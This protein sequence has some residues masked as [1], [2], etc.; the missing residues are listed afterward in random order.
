LNRLRNIAL[1]ILTLVLTQ[2]TAQMQQA[3]ALSGLDVVFLIDQSGSM[4]GRA[5]SDTS[6]SSRNDPNGVRFLATQFGIDWLGN[7]RA[8]QALLGNNLDVSASVIYFGDDAEVQLPLV[9]ITS[10]SPALWQEE[11]GALLTPLSEESYS[12]QN[13]GNT[14][15]VAAF[16]TA[17][18]EI[19]ADPDR[20]QVIILLTDGAPCAPER[21]VDE[22]CASFSDWH[23]HMQSVIDTA[24]QQFD[25]SNQYIY[26]VALVDTHIWSVVGNEWQVVSENGFS[27]RLER[28]EEFGIVFNEIL[29][30]SASQF[31]SAG[32]SARAQLGINVNLP[33]LGL[34]QSAI[35]ANNGTRELAIPPYQQLM[36]ISLFK[37]RADAKLILKNPYGD[38]LTS[39]SQ[40]V[41]VFGEGSL[42]EVW[43]V[44]NP[45]PGPWQIGTQ[46]EENGRALA[47]GYAYASVDLLRARFQLITPGGT[48]SMLRPITVAVEV[49]DAQD[50]V[51][52]LYDPQ[53][54]LS[55]ST[56]VTT[57]GGETLSLTLAPIN[58]VNRYGASFT[59]FEAGDYT[60][61]T[62]MAADEISFVE[63]K[64]ITVSPTETAIDGLGDTILEQTEQI[65][66]LHFWGQGGA[67]VEGITVE[68][69]EMMTV[70]AT[71]SCETAEGNVEHLPQPVEVDGV[72]TVRARHQVVGEGQRVCIRVVVR[73]D[74]PVAT[75]RLRTV[76]EGEYGRLT[77]RSVQPV[78]FH[79]MRP[80][81]FPPGGAR[82][83]Q[84]TTYVPL[85]PGIESLIQHPD[86]RVKPVE[87]AVELVDKI[88][89]LPLLDVRSQV[90]ADRFFAVQILDAA[91]QNILNQ[92]TYLRPTDHAARW[93]LTIDPLPPGNY[94]LVIQAPASPIGV[95]DRAILAED[96]TLRI[97]LMVVEDRVA[98][99][100]QGTIA[101]ASTVG[102]LALL[103]LAAL[104]IYRRTNAVKG[105]L[106][107]VRREPDGKLYPVLPSLLDLSN[108]KLRRVEIPLRDLPVVRP[109]LTRMTVRALN[110]GGARLDFEVNGIPKQR[111]TR[112]GD[113]TPLDFID[114]D[115]NE[116]FVLRNRT[117]K[118]GHVVPYPANETNA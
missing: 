111:D 43:Q 63:T 39:S 95:S 101:A 104:P 9:G 1:L 7:F 32:D 116:Y 53:Y 90:D 109:P 114:S 30:Q 107:F 45:V 12:G 69:F 14:D 91:D 105:T 59:P 29:T 31:I 54:R 19:P 74:A 34:G 37:S 117:V 62:T 18:R 80:E 6:A 82:P 28:P 5:F 65:Y 3:T 96:N 23:T 36:S 35:A 44:T 10:D 72:L 52:P 58:N 118:D 68:A 98:Q 15:F 16:Q 76:L 77:V 25:G 86:W 110:D 33:Q 41:S 49:L 102:G 48:P 17:F 106:L 40:G 22:N 26:S 27:Q 67:E 4:G 2:A 57:P 42:I 83:I 70:P 81:E 93:A 78:A 85:I 87:I 71:S 60:V 55:G 75:N 99:G 115:K 13:L 21:F 64:T 108:N 24:R 20:L 79:L 103:G 8:Q 97:P 56:T 50:E 92:Q 38:P 84:I 61:T 46:Y 100:L 66:T 112:P 89:A 51:L 11:R 88:S 73:D 94:T 113:P 47:D